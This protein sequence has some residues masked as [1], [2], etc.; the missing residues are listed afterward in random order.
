MNIINK[1]ARICTLIFGVC[2]LVLFFFPFVSV[3][4]NSEMINI[5]G[6]ELAFG[7]TVSAS[8][9][10]Y[11]L[12]HS[13]KF[14]LPA[15]LSLFASIAA[16]FVAFAKNP[17]ASRI[18]SFVCALIGGIMMLVGILS[19]VTYF[20]D[21]RPIFTNEAASALGLSYTSFPV[22]A[23]VAILLCAIVG[24]AGWLI[25]DYLEVL[26]SKG[27]KLTILQKVKKFIREMWAEIKKI[28]WPDHKSV[29]RNS[30]IVLIICA[31][32]G[33]FVWVVDLLLG[34]LVNF[35]SSL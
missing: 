33:S 14:L 34:V 35:I 25:N 15:L 30:I 8:E 20:T 11:N 17:K 3:P 23:T 2:A 26:A 24:I 32:I 1:I 9:T 12:A 10:T 5:S 22:F 16:G 13:V 21:L 4:V 28:V 18:V 19:K 27:Q 29:L 7:T 31:L 6:F